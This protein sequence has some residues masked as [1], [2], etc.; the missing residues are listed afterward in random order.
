MRLYV[1]RHGEAIDSTPG[2]PTDAMRW[3]TVR[4]RAGAREVGTVIRERDGGVERIVSSP[5]VRAVQTAEGMAGALGFADEIAVEPALAG[6]ESVRGL[7]ERVARHGRE[8]ASLLV[9]GHQPLVSALASALT[10]STSLP[11]AF[12]PA[13]AA[14]IDFDGAVAPGLGRI[15]FF[16]GPG[17]QGAV[18]P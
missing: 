15:V 9:V 18:A 14:R 17:T 7:V 3:L 11:F 13:F 2:G 10:G 8:A 12:G 16:A 6:A 5:L 4:G 1:C